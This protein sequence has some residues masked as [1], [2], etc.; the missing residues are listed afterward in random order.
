MRCSASLFSKW[1]SL[2]PYP[3]WHRWISTS[4]YTAVNRSYLMVFHFAFPARQRIF[5]HVSGCER[6]NLSPGITATKFAFVYG[7]GIRAPKQD[8]G[9]VVAGGNDEYKAMKKQLSTCAGAQPPSPSL[10]GYH[11][12]DCPLQ[13]GPGR[14]YTR[15]ITWQR[16]TQQRASLGESY[17]EE[18]LSITETGIRSLQLWLK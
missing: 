18:M 3:E 10:G 17:E 15:E 5:G 4:T 16:Q 2:P 12:F 13:R 1:A 8:R 6:K 14:A 11:R 7:C 9:P